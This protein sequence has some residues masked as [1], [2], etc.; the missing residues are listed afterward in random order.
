MSDACI[1]VFVL[2]FIC[3][4]IIIISELTLD[5]TLINDFTLL[6]VEKVIIFHNGSM[7]NGCTAGKK[8]HGL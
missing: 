3:A 8:V 2:V 5:L 1:K 6:C 4:S 7:G